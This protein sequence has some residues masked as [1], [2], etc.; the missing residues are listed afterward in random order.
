M[1]AANP[2][3][4]PFILTVLGSAGSHTG[5]GRACSGHLVRTPTTTLLLD[6]GNGST[7]NLQR[8]ARFADVDAV[9]ITHRHVDH[10][11]DLVSMF[12]AL[13]FDP[14]FDG[15]VDLYAP[16]EVRETLTALLS[17]DSALAFDR[18]FRCHEVR[19]GDQVQVGDVRVDVF[20][21]C[22]PPPSV[23]Y[24]ITAGDRILAY[25][26]DTAGDD[27]LLECAR[28]ADLFL[29]EATWQGDA[30]GFPEGIHLVAADA[31]RV[32]TRAGVRRLVLTHVAGGLDVEVS[33]AE[34][35]ATFDGPVDVA[36]DLHSWTP[37]R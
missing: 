26:G 18:V 27:A 2:S 21:A 36:E 7:A 12:H 34:A 11:V 22:H 17:S 6:A 8:L 24:R 32:A 23:S 33:R 16:A 31:G 15:R 25:S 29:C 35:A 4:A 13:W 28:D 37:D 20:D 30:A 10:C 5:P 14:T 19:G 3:E 1:E 9:F